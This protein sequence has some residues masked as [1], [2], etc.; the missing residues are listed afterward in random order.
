MTLLKGCGADLVREKLLAKASNAFWVLIDQSKRVQRIGENYPI[1]LEVMPF[2]W[3]LVRSSIAEIGGQGVNSGLTPAA[4][5]WR[6]PVT[7]VWFWMWFSNP[8]WIV[9]CLTIG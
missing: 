6:L 5:D 3:Q 7:A 1:P 2:A 8:A 9:R 4:T